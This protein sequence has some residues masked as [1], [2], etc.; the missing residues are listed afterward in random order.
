MWTEY[1]KDPRMRANMGIRR[2]LAPLLENDT[3]QLELFT[4]LLLFLPSVMDP[5]YGHQVV[6]RA[7][8]RRALPTGR[9]GAVLPEPGRL[10]LRH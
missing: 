9:R 4:A 2:R 7:V 5:V 3:N 10:R 6:N 1:A 8:G